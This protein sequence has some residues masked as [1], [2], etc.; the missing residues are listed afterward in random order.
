MNPSRIKHTV[1]SFLA[2]F[3]V[4]QPTTA[5]EL[6]PAS[7]IVLTQRLAG[8]GKD[9]SMLLLALEG[10][11]ADME[12]R[13]KSH[14]VEVIAVESDVD[15]LYLRV[16]IARVEDVLKWPEWSAVSLPFIMGDFHTLSANADGNSPVHRKPGI[17]PD[18]FTPR[19]NPY[20]GA[21][22]TESVQFKEAYPTYDGRGVVIGSNE[23]IDLRNPSLQVAYSL[24]GRRVPKIRDYVM[25]PPS[26]R[27]IDATTAVASHAWLST[28]L[29]TPDVQGYVT[30]KDRRFALPADVRSAAGELR[31]AQVPTNQFAMGV[32]RLTLLW[33]VP[34]SQV[35]F[36]EHGTDER[37]GERIGAPIPLPKLPTDPHRP[38]V[39]QMPAGDSRTVMVAVDVPSRAITAR[40]EG[41]MTH[42][43][44]CASVAVGHN[45]LG[46]LAEGVAP[47]AQ[48]IVVDCMSSLAS[49]N[50]YE[51]DDV[52]EK[53][54]PVVRL[55][56]DPRVDLLSSST[57]YENSRHWTAQRSQFFGQLLDRLSRRYPKAY[58]QAAS[59]AGPGEGLF[60]DSVRPSSD[61]ITVGAYI[62]RESWQANYGLVP[63]LAYTPAP[64]SSFGPAFDGALKPDLLGVTGTLSVQK[65]SHPGDMAS[66]YFD[67]PS[68]LGISGGTSA[69]TP[70]AAGHGALLISAA[71]QA[72]IPYDPARLR[73]ALFSTAKFLDGVEARVQGHGLIQVQQAW[74]ALQK[75]KQHTP[76]AFQVQAPVRTPF[77]DRLTPAHVGRG[78]YERIG[79]GPSQK[80][81]RVIT[82]TRTSGPEVPLSYWLRWK[83]NERKAFASTL[84]EVRLP[85]NV[86]VQIPISIATGAS[87]S[88]SA[89]LNLID[90]TLE[91]VAHSVMCTV[92]AAEQ[93]GPENGYTVAIKRSVP[94]PGHG[95]VY[96]H[97]PEGATALRVEVEQRGGKRM[98]LSAL[99]PHGSRPRGEIQK[100]GAVDDFA[101]PWVL[102]Q[103][104]RERYDQTF[105]NPEPGVWQIWMSYEDGYTPP[106]YDPEE[107]QPARGAEAAFR[108][109]SIGARS[110]VAGEQGAASLQFRN[111]MGAIKRSSIELMGIGAQNE[112]EARL[113]PTLTPLF[114]EV[115][116]PEGTSRLT[117]EVAMADDEQ[118]SGTNVALAIFY[119]TG[120][121][122]PAVIRMAADLWPGSKKFLEIASPRAGRYRISLEAWGAVPADGL[123]VRYRDTVFHPVFGGAA[124]G[125][126]RNDAHNRDLK[127]GETLSSGA[128]VSVRA[129]PRD[130]RYLVA[131]FGLFGEPYVHLSRP[132]DGN[133][134]RMAAIISGRQP[135]ELELR[136]TRVPLAVQ[137]IRLSN[138]E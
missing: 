117:A 63:A 50:S 46:S 126:E 61:A 102:P 55:F 49:R 105:A 70:N 52:Y 78:L 64:F 22:V 71:K 58:F 95:I 137:Q 30:F 10:R 119:V 84:S 120:Q 54:M 41:H 130:G 73:M 136:R 88:Y 110:T 79:W 135:P 108:V 83:G 39:A 34:Q 77:S 75:L 114:Y 107:S 37:G 125:N 138:G 85:L 62:P 115:D 98:T 109:T 33:N 3:C 90:P 5:L 127:R 1:L 97:V 18:A 116:V 76:S 118:I 35:W 25:L 53:V 26:G 36:Y 111:Q 38:V 13:A 42:G 93:L 134:R 89:I 59:N 4:A 9:L 123:K 132:E 99:T 92:I 65:P 112:T 2:V 129:R 16:P 72:G 6:S 40:T 100:G 60:A 87:G 51:N 80:G 31:V 113:P 19:D 48:W 45:F 29:V 27:S 20:T 104:S 14:G 128:G 91:L 106:E 8:G 67:A 133:M 47:A 12:K 124:S 66:P 86:P 103:S 74:N 7:R 21:S 23:A 43:D 57:T 44:M 122:D 101:A 68:W 28:T 11:S 81:N 24:E 121:A 96:G 15:M 82:I 17:A 32:S 56:R 69:A 94:R 131:E